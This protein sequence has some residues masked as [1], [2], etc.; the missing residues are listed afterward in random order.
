MKNFY[1]L[2]ALLSILLSS[3][4][5]AAEIETPVLAQP[6]TNPPPAEGPIT[7]EQ[8]TPILDTSSSINNQPQP[9]TT[10]SPPAAATPPMINN[11]PQAPTLIN[12]PSA[13]T[14]PMIN[15]QPQAPVV[16]N[17]PTAATPPLSTTPATP[18]PGAI[19]PVIGP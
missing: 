15:N 6:E 18:P 2:L 3:F 9:P 17:P 5:I 11:Q 1:K 16:I 19:A 4:A 8:L 14:P 13:A 10:I 12:P 7:A